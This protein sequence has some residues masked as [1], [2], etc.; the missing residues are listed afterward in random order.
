MNPSKNF[1][2]ENLGGWPTHA[3]GT[4][5]LYGPPAIDRTFALVIPQSTITYSGAW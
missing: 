1:H 2:F 4:F 5:E 3:S